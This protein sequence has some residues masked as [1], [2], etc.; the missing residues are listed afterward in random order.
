MHCRNSG[1]SDFSGSNFSFLF[2]S[3][4]KDERSILSMVF[5]RTCVSVVGEDCWGRGKYNGWHVVRTSGT[6]LIYLQMLITVGTY[7]GGL[8]GWSLSDGDLKV[9]F[10]FA[11][12]DGAVK[13]LASGYYQ[14][15]AVLASG[16]SD[17]FIK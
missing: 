15:K 12:H 16:S 7:N 6:V 11:A 4:F 13:S 2:T 8:Q 5:M 14:G 1:S 3:L 9:K 10:S 17:E